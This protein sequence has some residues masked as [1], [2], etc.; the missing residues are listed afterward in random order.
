VTEIPYVRQPIELPARYR[1]GPDSFRRPGVARGT[2]HERRWSE[3][4]VFP[5]T[6]RRYWVYV[7]ALY[8]ERAPAA[9]MVFQDAEWYLDL[10]REVRAPVVLDNLI[11]DR[12]MPVTIVVFVEPSE[13]RNAEYDAFGDEYARFL[14]EEIIPAVRADYSVTDAPEDW[15]IAGGSS[16]GN[17]AFTAAWLRPD[18]FRRVYCTLG[19]FAQMPDGNPYPDLIRRT[20]RKPLR[21]WL[22][23]ANRDLNWNQP[24]SNWLSEN[25]QVAAALAERG[26]DFRL[27]VGDGGHDGNH[28]GVL[29]PDALR[30]LWRD[31]AR[32]AGKDQGR[33]NSAT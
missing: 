19:S 32:A 1:H 27:L 14:L 5:G 7:P 23:A 30:W 9:L 25:L 2:L 18:A 24:R 31:R 3:S 10:D 21:I 13:H 8:D 4:R 29:L 26:Y 15:A 22:H 20:E 17:C 12:A 6:N 33:P 28:G 16:G 11:H